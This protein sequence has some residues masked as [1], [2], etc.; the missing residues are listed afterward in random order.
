MFLCFCKAHFIKIP[1][2]WF[3]KMS[4]HLQENYFSRVVLVFHNESGCV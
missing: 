2:C 3:F 4:V 1:I